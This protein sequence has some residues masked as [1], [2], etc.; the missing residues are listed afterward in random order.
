MKPIEVIPIYLISA[1]LSFSVVADDAGSGPMILGKGTNLAHWLSQ[2]RRT[3]E[4]RR[5][6]ITEK[7]I[8]YI[9]GL[10]FDHVR[11]PLDEQQMWD[12]D[13][14][15]DEDA[16][17][18]MRHAI[19]WSLEHGLLVVIDLHILR[20]HYFD[21]AEKPL[22]TETAAQDQFIDLW[23]DL[24]SALHEYPTDKVA[25][26]LM[27]EP[28]ADDPA[29]WNKVLARAFAAVREREPERTMVIGS[30]RWQSADT[31]DE[32]VVPDDDHI[33]LSF[34]FYEPFLLTHDA[35]PWTAF[36]NY[37]GP[38]HYPGVILSQAEFDALTEDQQA[39][40]S[41]WVGR[42]FNRQILE[43]MMEKPLR[44]AKELNLPLYCGE[45]GVYMAA[46]M[47]DRLRWYR[48]MLAIFDKNSISSANWNYKSDEF[49]L[50]G[51]DGQPIEAI[52]DVL[53]G[54]EAPEPNRDQ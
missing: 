13:G 16:F 14:N 35:A 5:D 8:A 17:A 6:F 50:V 43:S 41:D 20:S 51:L 24:S 9:A 40:A 39:I 44:R 22:W 15:R 18:I 10:G 1:L 21:A 32:L 38:V 49:G 30:N 47:P 28:V 12:E 52:R 7:D 33:I 36:K 19:D 23:T 48:D 37:T 2:T 11:L 29:D 27:N 34:H 31:F 25:Y 54:N 46:P 45:Y 42:E 26:E 3:G 53:T 4:E